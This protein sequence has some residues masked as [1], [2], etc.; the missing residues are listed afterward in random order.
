MAAYTFK[1]QMF[2]LFCT[3]KR[4]QESNVNQGQS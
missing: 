2:I 4:P 3:M 1:N